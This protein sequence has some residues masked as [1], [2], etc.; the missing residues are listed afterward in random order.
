M[1]LHKII[2]S[3]SHLPWHVVCSK[4]IFNFFE[5]HENESLLQEEHFISV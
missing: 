2:V 5:S 4:L 1:W 3:E